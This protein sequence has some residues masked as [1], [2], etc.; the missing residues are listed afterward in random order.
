MR[1]EI[2]VHKTESFIGKK[3]NTFTGPMRDIGE[4]VLSNRKD[5]KFHRTAESRA[6]AA[7]FARNHN[8]ILGPDEDINGDG[9]NDVVL[10]NQ[11]GEPVLI[12]G[13]GV[14]P[15]EAPYRMDYNSRYQSKIAR[16][17]VGGYSGYM[18]KLRHG[19]LDIEYRKWVDYLDQDEEFKQYLSE[20]LQPINLLAFLRDIAGFG[21]VH[22]SML[23]SNEDAETRVDAKQVAKRFKLELTDTLTGVRDRLIAQAF[24]R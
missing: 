7:K 22:I 21:Q 16:Y 24:S 17:N 12:D 20:Q 8:L 5:I 3:L 9:I 11:K 2:P 1:R 19:E 10:Y 18:N 23:P 14:K 4:V 15:S 6:G 13:Y